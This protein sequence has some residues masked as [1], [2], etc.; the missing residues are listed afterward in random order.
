ME[1]YIVKKLISL[2]L[3]LV[4]VTFMVPMTVSADAKPED[5]RKYKP[6]SSFTESGQKDHNRKPEKD[7]HHQKDKHKKDKKKAPVNN[8]DDA[9]HTSTGYGS[10]SEY[11]WFQYA[12]GCKFNVEPHVDPKD[13]EDDYCICG[14]H[15]SSNA[16]L[17]TLWVD[18][19]PPIKKFNKNTTEYKLAAYTYKDVKEIKIATNTYNSQATVE[20]PEDL[21]LKEGENKFEVKVTAENQKN[22]KVYT[23]IIMKEAKK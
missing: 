17:V 3:A 5:S 15:F 1:E 21:T 23:L 14:Y 2:L 13:T 20:L 12:C 7:K 19:C 8:H 9:N 4:L 16:D 10:N 22:T 11:H 18:G 6:G